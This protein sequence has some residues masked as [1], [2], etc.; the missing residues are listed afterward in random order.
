MRAQRK[1]EKGTHLRGESLYSSFCGKDEQGRVSELGLA[2]LNHFRGLWSVGTVPS[3][4]VAGHGV[5]SGPEHE[6]SEKEVLGCGVWIGWFVFD[7]HNCRR[8][9]YYL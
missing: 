2:S 4:L 7:K 9:V 5:D 8:V 6:S 1:T 3:G